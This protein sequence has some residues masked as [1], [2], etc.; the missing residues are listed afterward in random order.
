MYNYTRFGK[1]GRSLVLLHGFLGGTGYW[2]SVVT[3][4]KDHYDVISV[5]L[6]GFAGSAHMPAPDSMSGCASIVFA[7]MDEL[8]VS[9]FSLLGFSMGGMIAQQAAL[10]QPD[11]I[12]SLVLY[13]SAAVGDLPNRF[14]SWE[15]SMERIRRE[16]VEAV[17]DRTVATWFV[18]GERHPN[19]AACRAACRGANADSCISV[20]RAMQRWSALDRLHEI[21]APALVIVG[22]KD[23]ST[24][25]SESIAL[26]Q[27]IAGSLL[28][29]LPDCA[30][31]A[32]LER[33]DLFNAIVL[34]FLLKT[35]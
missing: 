4:L 27:G 9:K 10:D 33:P 17:A 20:M 2:T 11:R 32:H 29:V 34:D 5:D 12:T 28:C 21:T 8:G 3:A 24:R 31:G 1:K 18:D 23:R 16:G 19:H 25:P 26:W 30:H 14:E 22:D 6:P 35:A 13:G 7:L 15:A